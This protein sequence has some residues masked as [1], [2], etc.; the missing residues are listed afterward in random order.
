MESNI[1]VIPHSQSL[2]KYEI[3]ICI[4]VVFFVLFSLVPFS[5]C[6]R[7]GRRKR[8]K[9]PSCAR[10]YIL[11]VNLFRIKKRIVSCVLRHC[12]MCT[13]WM[14]WK[15]GKMI[16]QENYQALT[17]ELPFHSPQQFIL[18]LNELGEI[19]LNKSNVRNTFPALENTKR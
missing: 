2:C 11:C 9:A 19:A 6:L 12:D 3:L 5:F 18:C 15:P 13:S 1:N 4:K 14:E 8:S 10:I 16:V 7:R 17:D